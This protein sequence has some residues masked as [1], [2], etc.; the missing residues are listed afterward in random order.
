MVSI[1]CCDHVEGAFNHLALV[2][3]DL[4]DGVVEEGALSVNEGAEELSHAWKDGW[5]RW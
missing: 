3:V 1:Q 5:G 2:I 4:L